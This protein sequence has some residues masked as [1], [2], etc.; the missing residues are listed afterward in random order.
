MLFDTSI[1][2]IFFCLTKQVVKNYKW[3]K[4]MKRTRLGQERL[5]RREERWKR[6]IKYNKKGVNSASFPQDCQTCTHSVSGYI[7]VKTTFCE[8]QII[9]NLDWWASNLLLF[10]SISDIF[11]NISLFLV[12]TYDCFFLIWIN[13]RTHRATSGD[14]WRKKSLLVAG[15]QDF[16]IC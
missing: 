8:N 9:D 16:W 5:E 15:K 2:T 12:I 11:C 10:R 4:M 13:Y 3:W 1:I 14:I 6:N 7:G